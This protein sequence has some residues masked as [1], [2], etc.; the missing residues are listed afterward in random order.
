VRKMSKVDWL[1]TPNGN[2]PGSLA[3]APQMEAAE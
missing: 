2:Q 3:V 1:D